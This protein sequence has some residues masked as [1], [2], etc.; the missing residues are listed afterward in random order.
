MKYMKEIN[1]KCSSQNF[2]FV[3]SS[4]DTEMY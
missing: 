1:I 2:L 4:E 3:V